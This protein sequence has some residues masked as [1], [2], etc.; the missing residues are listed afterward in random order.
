VQGGGGG[1]Q[2]DRASGCISRMK[3]WCETRR[4]LVAIGENH[5]QSDEDALLVGDTERE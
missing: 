4:F 1:P 3:S 2:N 5:C